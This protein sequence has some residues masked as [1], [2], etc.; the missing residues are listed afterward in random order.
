MNR[1]N[2]QET[3][4]YLVNEASDYAQDKAAEFLH[5]IDSGAEVMVFDSEV[6]VTYSE[7]IT[8]EQMEE[9]QKVYDAAFEE[10][11]ADL[12]SNQFVK[13]AAEI[14][15]DWIGGYKAEATKESLSVSVDGQIA[16]TVN[17]KYH[18]EGEDSYAVE[19]LE[20]MVNR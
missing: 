11:L 18:V 20:Y 4:A 2:I 12:N 14:N 15:K 16:A 17:S 10:K 6:R 19:Q 13:W 5:A 3:P 1:N 9:A 7:I 8:E